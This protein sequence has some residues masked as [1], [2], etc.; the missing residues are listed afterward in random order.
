MC[1]I[2]ECSMINKRYGS[3]DVLLLSIYMAFQIW[4]VNQRVKKV[5]SVYPLI[6]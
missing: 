2:K 5:A 3:S 4:I 6:R 1:Q